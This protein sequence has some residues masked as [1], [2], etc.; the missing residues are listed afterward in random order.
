MARVRKL[1]EP[2]IQ[3][4]VLDFRLSG[5]K[6][7]REELEKLAAELMP[8]DGQRRPINSFKAKLVPGEGNQLDIKSASSTFDGF[9]LHDSRDRVV[10][11]VYPHRVTV[12]HVGDYISWEEL[13]SDATRVLQ[14]HLKV[15]GARKVVRVA[16]RY[17]NRLALPGPEFRDWAQILSRP[18]VRPN[19]E[20]G[21]SA[22]QSAWVSDFVYKEVVRGLPSGFAAIVTTATAESSDQGPTNDLI[23]DVDVYKQCELLPDP[24]LIAQSVSEIRALKNQLFFGALTE[25]FLES[26]K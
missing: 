17:I 10:V 7:S 21:S 13:L 20:E 26:Y 25:S 14:A 6:A 12:S 15:T 11:Q 4:A 9:A 8:P 3:E 16:A 23:V 5:S 1:V 22:F 19:D 24:D 18:P 2:P